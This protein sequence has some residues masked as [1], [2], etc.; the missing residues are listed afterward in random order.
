[1]HASG[2]RQGSMSMDMPHLHYF[3]QDMLEWTNWIQTQYETRNLN[4]TPHNWQLFSNCSQWQHPTECL[5]GQCRASQAQ[6]NC[7]EI[8]LAI[9]ELLKDLHFFSR[10]EDCR[11]R[12]KVQAG[13]AQVDMR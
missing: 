8:V 13:G 3:T 6:K 11:V 10:Y 9:A 1:M 7:L 12:V 5:Y 4:F 2:R